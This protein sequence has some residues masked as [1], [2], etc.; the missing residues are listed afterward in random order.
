MLDVKHLRRFV[1]SIF[2]K[3]RCFNHVRLES[4]GRV[5]WNLEYFYEF[6]STVSTCSLVLVYMQEIPQNYSPA[7]R[8]AS[9]SQSSKVLQFSP[10]EP[11]QHFLDT[12]EQLEQ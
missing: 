12:C 11:L 1:Y 8:T 7:K 5:F 3:M 4:I 2:V 10:L 6:T 9:C